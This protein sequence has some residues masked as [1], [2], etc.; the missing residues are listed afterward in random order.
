M[1]RTWLLVSAVI[2]LAGTLLFT[3]IVNRAGSTQEPQAKQ[4]LLDASLSVIEFMPKG[5]ATDGT[6]SYQAELQKAI[7]AAAATG[8]T[9]VFPRMIYRLD[10]SGLQLRS[11]LT[12]SMYGA[13][14]RLGEKCQKA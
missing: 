13:T 3:L 14:F 9:L 5:Y 12:M 1:R 4:P 7:D 10:E 8:R 11:N 6:V 2:A